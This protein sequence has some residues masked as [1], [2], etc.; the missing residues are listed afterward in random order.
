MSEAIRRLAGQLNERFADSWSL[1][2]IEDQKAVAPGGRSGKP[3]VAVLLDRD[4]AGIGK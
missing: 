2:V 4:R 3:R 1:V